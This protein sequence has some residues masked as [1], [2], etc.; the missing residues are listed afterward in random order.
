MESLQN[1]VCLDEATEIYASICKAMCSKVCC[2]SVKI[3]LTYI[4]NKIAVLPDKLTVED[5]E[6]SP[7]AMSHD[8]PNLSILTESSIKKSSPF[9]MHFKKTKNL[10]MSEITEDGI[11]N[12]YWS[13]EIL[14]VFE[15]FMYLYPV[16]SGLMLKREGI[17]RDTNADVENWF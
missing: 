5:Q 15:M 16:W 2:E 14:K 7:S 8:E 11:E 12:D 10:A 17:T 13:Q 3:S 1:S 9:K 4:K 6:L